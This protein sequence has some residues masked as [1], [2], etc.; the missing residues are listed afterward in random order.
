MRADFRQLDGRAV[1]ALVY[2]AVGLTCI[3]YLKDAHLL[4]SLLANTP[5]AEIGAEAA[6]PTHD[7][8]YGLSWWV[9]VSVFFYF[10]VPALAVVLFQKRSLRDIGLAPRAE[11][12]FLKL[13]T[14]CIV[15]M[16]PL[17]YL[18]SLTD[19]FSAKYPFLAMREGIP[20]L[21]QTLLIWELAYFLQFFGLEFFF[22]GFLVHSLKPVLGLYS[23]LVM[24]VPYTMIHFQKPMP[25]AFAAIFAG[26]F[27]GWISYRNGTIWLGLVLHCTVALAMDIMALWN[28]GLIF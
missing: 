27:L 21:G 13:L 23:V 16:L 2:T 20:Y 11:P 3:A 25:E 26:L 8:L 18:M 1:F 28:K 19:G 12:G 14:V 9:V 7:N 17:V 4:A 24:T 15:V 5:W 6:G 10:V 22:R